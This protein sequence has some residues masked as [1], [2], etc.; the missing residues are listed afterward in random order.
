MIHQMVLIVMLIPYRSFFA[1]GIIVRETIIAKELGDMVRIKTYS[2]KTEED[3]LILFLS[4]M[5]LFPMG[6]MYISVT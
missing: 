4:L 3:F 6:L 1:G 2:P 5:M